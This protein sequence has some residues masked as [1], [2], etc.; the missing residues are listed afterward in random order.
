MANHTVNHAQEVLSAFK[1]GLE[2]QA[3]EYALEHSVSI[4]E[5]CDYSVYRFEDGTCVRVYI[6]D[7]HEISIFEE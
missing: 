6:T 3:F 4:R 5:A 1:A 2:L 7:E